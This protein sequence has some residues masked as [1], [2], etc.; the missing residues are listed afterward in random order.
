EIPGIVQADGTN[1]YRDMLDLSTFFQIV[2]DDEPA[3]APPPDDGA[4]TSSDIGTAEAQAAEAIETKSSDTTLQDTGDKLNPLVPLSAW[5]AGSGEAKPKLVLIATSGGAYRASFWTALVLDELAKLEAAGEIPGFCR[6]VRLITGASGGMVGGAYFTAMM[7]EDGTPP[8]SLLDQIED[9]ILE[10]QRNPDYTYVRRFPLPRD[11][12]SAVCQ[13]LIQGDIPG[14]FKAG[15]R[16]MDRGKV[17]EEQWRTINVSF[18][19]MRAQEA[20]GKRPS[21]LF[22]P[23]LAETGQPLL[24]SNLD[25]NEIRPDDSDEAVEF[26]DW[27][28]HSRDSFKLNTAVRLNASFPYIA[29]AS[30]LPTKP[31]RRV[32][33]AGYYDNYGVDLAVAYLAR[34]K[35]RDWVVANTSGVVLLQ[36]RAFPFTP[37]GLADPSPVA[38]ALQFLTTPIEGFGTARGSTMKSRNSQSFRRLESMYYLKAG[39]GFLRT[40]IFGVDSKTSLSWYMPQR[41]LDEMR[42]PDGWENEGNQ[43]AV[44]QLKDFWH[45]D[46]AATA[47]SGPS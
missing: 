22:S 27:F 40:I 36:L 13:Q 2:D 32:V 47:P 46:L 6:N 3:T 16:E 1:H 14:L 17:L 25:L 12:L 7:P 39:Q 5:R 34:P 31:Y 42:G 19:K 38:R 41:E 26:F 9:D 33:D 11:S 30:A 29:P 45:R 28:K 15:Y 24:I 37:P 8:P 18:G 35:I 44:A 23:M 10:T 43:R 4:K 20:A 21:I